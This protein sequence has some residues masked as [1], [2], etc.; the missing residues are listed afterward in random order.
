ML[1]RSAVGSSER[2][3]SNNGKDDKGREEERGK[4][5]TESCGCLCGEERRAT[6]DARVGRGHGN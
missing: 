2:A 4:E 1:A 5:L 6:E 3:V